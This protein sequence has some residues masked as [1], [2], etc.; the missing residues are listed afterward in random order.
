MLEIPRYD[1]N[2]QLEYMLREPIDVPR[3]TKL[4]VT[5]WYDNSAANPANPDPT[6]LVRFGDQ[7]WD[8]MMIG[9]FT[10]HKLDA[11]PAQPQQTSRSE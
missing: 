7:T 5:A 1:F 10:G 4:K 3:G 2:W 8:E 11:D 9:Y 6:K